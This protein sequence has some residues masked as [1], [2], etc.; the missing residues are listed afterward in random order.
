MDRKALAR[1]YKETR[2]RADWD[3]ADDLRV[4][5]KLW[6]EKLAPFGERGYHAVPK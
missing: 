3:P 6:L 2:R 5:E 1:Q 4:L